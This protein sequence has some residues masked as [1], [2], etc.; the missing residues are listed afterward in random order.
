MTA[1][2]S[3]PVESKSTRP[4]WL[5]GCLT[6][7]AILFLIPAT[8]NLVTGS[9]LAYI[10]LSAG[11]ISPA[12]IALLLIIAL[13]CI[14]YFILAFRLK[15]Q[16]WLISV[17][18]L[19]LAWL[20]LPLPLPTLINT[21]TMRVR[22]DGFSMMP[23]LPNGSYMIA[24]R[25][26]YQRQLPQRGDVVLLQDPASSGSD[27]MQVKRVIGLPGEVVTIANG[28]VSING[29]PLN[30]PYIS[31]PAPYAGEWKIAEGQYFVLGDNRPDSRDSH[32]LGTISRESILAKVVW[33]YWPFANFGKIADFNSTP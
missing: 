2:N 27:R 31:T 25:Q 21:A 14:I 10:F 1:S 7:L 22:N 3:L 18:L 11:I 29:T 4:V 6:A 12:A 19:A 23:A 28:Q 30:E 33:I 8:L 16:H 17:A 24:D 13:S 9:I 5:S 32:Q 15:R 20:V 26:I